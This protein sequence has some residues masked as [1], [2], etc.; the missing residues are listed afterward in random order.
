MVP[1]CGSVGFAGEGLSPARIHIFRLKMSSLEVKALWMTSPLFQDCL[2]TFDEIMM[3]RI[4]K[5]IHPWVLLSKKMG[6]RWKKYSQRFMQWLKLILL[7][8][9]D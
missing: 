3:S 1:K 6:Q 8:H 7:T 5:H 9:L 2:I 4:Q